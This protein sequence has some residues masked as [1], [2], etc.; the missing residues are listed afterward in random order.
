MY[1][2]DTLVSIIATV[3]VLVELGGIVSA[4]HA[5][6]GSRSSQGA[7]AWAIALVALPLITLPLYWIFGRTKFQ[8]YVKALREGAQ[9]HSEKVERILYH[10]NTEHVV[11][12]AQ[13]PADLNVY[14]KL[15][16]HPFTSGNECELLIDGEA[17][18]GAMLASI[19]KAE[20]YILMQYYIVKDDR[21]GSEVQQH[22]TAKAR[23]GIKVYFLYDEI[24]CHKLPN[25]YLETLAL[26]GVEV[27][28]FKTTQGRGN[29]FQINFRNHRKITVVDGKEAFV[30]GHNIGDEYMGRNPRF[31]RWRDTHV[32][33][34]GPVVRQIQLSFQ[35]DWF[36]ATRR[37]LEVDWAAHLS[38]HGQQ[39]ALSLSTGPD[40]DIGCCSLMF[41]H[42]IHSARR[43]IWITSPYFVPSNAVFEALQVAALRG[44]DVRI[45][46]PLKPDHRTVYLAGFAYMDPLGAKGVRFFRYQPGFLHAKAMLVDD[47][48]AVVGT[49]NTDNRSFRLNFEI[50]LL[51]NDTRFA[52]QVQRMF[53]DDFAHSRPVP[54][55]DFQQ[56]G[57]IF[58]ML[59]RFTNLLSPIL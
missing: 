2:S 47:H 50:S 37:A 46:L 19:D 51:V 7:I 55:D 27:S 10:I 45:L 11:P 12:T 9:A 48:L 8:G 30:G 56:R 52:A 3:F 1:L 16:A 29:R 41:V 18:F 5:V 53:E 40:D 54:T 6:M 44:V 15:A 39:N 14:T 36:W 42:A 13:L 57:I 31:G 4:V 23:A 38:G 33:V 35:Q 22:L 34:T 25:T 49:A 21:L 32:K 26:A 28:G 58:K 43:R 59:V 17:T 20:Q 24:G